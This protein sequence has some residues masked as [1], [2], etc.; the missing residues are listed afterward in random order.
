MCGN[1][2]TVHNFKVK[3]LSRERERKKQELSK[4]TPNWIYENNIS[5]SPMSVEGEVMSFSKAINFTYF[6]KCT[7]H[8]EHDWHDDECLG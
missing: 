2:F 4:M 1:Q 3:T 5:H 6:M 8:T 7:L